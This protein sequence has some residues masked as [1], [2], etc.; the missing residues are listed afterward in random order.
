MRVD[1][2]S[3][4][5]K[6][7]KEQR[8]YRRR[9]AVFLCL[10]VLVAFG[11][12]AALKLYGQAMTHKME[13]LDCQYTVHEHT[14]ECY[15]RDAEGNLGTEAVCGYA[16]YVIHQHNDECYDKEGRLVCSLEE[17][18]PH[19]HTEECWLTEKVLVCGE[20]TGEARDGGEALSGEE[21]PEN[22]ADLPG[23]ETPENGEALPAAGA[24]ES[25]TASV[26]E[27][28]SDQEAAEEVSSDTADIAA[29]VQ[30][31]LICTA[32]VHKHE[33][34]C[35]EEVLSC[36]F[37]EEHTHGEECLNRTLECTV[38]EHTHGEGCYDAEGKLICTLEE[39]THKIGC[40]DSDGNLICTEELHTHGADCMDG[41]GNIVCG[42][43][44]HT[45]HFG[46]CYRQ[47]HI[48]G[49]ETHTH[50][51]SCYTQKLIC[52]MEEHEHTEECYAQPEPQSEEAGVGES[53][54]ASEVTGEVSVPEIPTESETQNPAEGSEEGA[55]EHVHTEDCY[56]EVRTLICGE[57][58]LH[59][60]DNSCY[61]SD[62]FDEE[63]NLIQ[64]SRPSCGLL[65]L[66]E[67]M[68]VHTD[69]E[70]SCFKTVEL[71]PEEVAALN[72][73]AKLHIHE[74]SCYDGEGNLICGHNATHIHIPECYDETGKL[75]CGYGEEEKKEYY[76]GKEEH[77]H[78]AECCDAEGNLTC[79]KGE[80]AHDESCQEE[81]A[82]LC[83]KE[84][85][86]HSAEC[87][88]TEGNLTCEK[89]EHAH[90]E[91]CLEKQ[92]EPENEK[93][94][95]GIGYLVKVTYPDS[96]KISEKAELI[97]RQITEESDPERFA[98]RQAEARE[99]LENENINVHAL[100]DI[101][102]YLDGEE[103]EPQDTVNVTI[104]LLDENGLPEGTPMQIV[105]FAESGNE[106]LESGDIDSEGNAN[107]ETD[108]FSEF[109]VVGGDG[110]IAIITGDG[111]ESDDAEE[112]VYICGKEEHTHGEGCYDGS[113]NLICS[114][115][116]HTHD[117]SCL[118][119]SL[120]ICGEREHVHSEECYDENQTLICEKKE[121]THEAACLE[122]KA[123][124][125]VEKV[126][127]LIAAL[128]DQ[129]E[130]AGK[131]AEY[132]EAE[133][134]DE[135]AYAA[136]TE[137]LTVQIQDAYNAYLGLN[138][139]LRKYVTGTDYLL[140]LAEIMG[141]SLLDEQSAN[142]EGVPSYAAFVPI[143]E[144]GEKPSGM[145][146]ELLYGD[147]NSTH[148]DKKD[149]GGETPNY[150]NDTMQGYF[151]LNTTGV[152]GTA[153]I[154]EVT[155]SLYIP[156]EY[157]DKDKIYIPEFND[158]IALHEISKVTEETRDGKGYYKISLKLKN[159]TPT[160]A[161]KFSFNMKFK[162]AEV[163]EDYELK[164]FATL[165]FGEGDG[166]KK[167]S[168][169]E[170]I[171]RPK[172]EDPII[173]KYVNTNK[174]D[175]MKDDDTRV[176][177]TVSEAGL[178]EDNKYVSF[179]Y[180]LG[181][182]SW[183]LR[184]YDKITLTDKLPLYKDVNGVDR[185]AVFDEAANPG[186]TYNEQEHTVS[187]VFEV[188]PEW[189][190]EG[191]AKYDEKLMKQIQEAELKL[192]FPGCKIDG[193]EEKEVEGDNGESVIKKFFTKRLT[194][195][196][197]A[198]CEP[199]KPSEEESPDTC[200]DSIDFILTS[201][202]GADG[203]FAKGNSA[204]T[205]M[206]TKIARSAA[207]KWSLGFKNKSSSNLVNLVIGDLE[208]D[209]RLKFHSIVFD[210]TTNKN[211]IQNLAYVE[212]FTYDNGG[213]TG[214]GTPANP[215]KQGDIYDL[216]DPAKY[217]E[218]FKDTGYSYDFGA[219]TWTLTLDPEKEYKGIK[220]YFKDGFTVPVNGE[221]PTIWP[222][223]TFRNPDEKRFIE[224]EENKAENSYWNKA[225]IAY[226]DEKYANPGDTY[227]FLF[228]ENHFDL[229]GN[230]ENLWI[231]KS[232]TQ[233]NWN[234]PDK[235]DNGNLVYDYYNKKS[236]GFFYL[237]VKG[238]LNEGKD[239]KNLR[240]IDLLPEALEPY[241][242]ME[243]GTGDW[244]VK[245]YQVIPNYHN[246][247][248]TAMI[249]YL[250][251]DEV[252][253]TLDVWDG[254]SDKYVKFTPKVRVKPDA[255]PGTFVNEVY[256]LG[257]D[258]EEPPTDHDSKADIYEMQG[259]DKTKL[260]RYG[261]A[262]GSISTAEALYAEKFIAKD[263][264]NDW[265][266]TTLRFKVGDSFQYKLSLNN[267]APD[268]SHTNLTVYDVLPRIDDRSINNQVSRGSE[269]TVNLKGALTP[270]EGYQVW[271]TTSDEVYKK[272]MASLV[273]EE[274]I[275]MQ[276]IT[277]WSKVT[278]FKFMANEDVVFSTGKIEF[279]VPVKI[280]ETLTGDS[281]KILDEKSAQDRETGTA[282]VLEATNSFGY[283]TGSFTTAQNVESNYVKAQIS[284]AGF[285][286]QKTDE[287]GRI[288]PGAE[289]K[290]EKQKESTSVPPTQ[291][292]D[293][294]GE[295]VQ[296]DG[297]G[298]T[299]QDSGDETQGNTNQT[300]DWEQIGTTV[301][302]DADGKISFKNLT[303]G[304]YR[305]TEVKAPDGYK[306]LE[307]PITVT[308][309]LNETT[310]EYTVTAAGLTGSGTGNDPFAIVNATLY[311]LP[312]TGGM[313]SKLYTMA[314]AAF[315]TFGAGFLYKKKFRERRA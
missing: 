5:G 254:K 247:G 299:A 297:E 47:E 260:I 119:E 107:F 291:Q 162:T 61:A 49:K 270:P 173:T 75:I 94:C 244:Y 85:H 163:P 294:P 241:E 208:I 259:S 191:A 66:E 118:E 301:I 146:L 308:I 149:A 154:N 216:T 296:S 268:T 309:T 239:Y 194:N 222:F 19:T 179:W 103:I 134:A 1:F 303:V 53:Q 120:Y 145:V 95:E 267:T 274:S 212:A 187:R 29:W 109:M 59:T 72:N 298:G 256:L 169:A 127:Q 135:E 92:A 271:Y 113:Q 287:K 62:C 219:W 189:E 252:R 6:L 126:N 240:V 25:E 197:S 69:N 253:K 302:S 26:E 264:S 110:N 278:A 314:G 116:E 205:I 21:T 89:E 235:D 153:T 313:G 55:K 39:H 46:G 132:E 98:Q 295:S 101:G 192:R 54:S 174:F 143:G 185:Y 44:E 159:Y 289:F 90:D 78:G 142:P 122:A 67:H 10:A 312:E 183:S 73:G 217:A 220:I 245:E 180:K 233:D 2:L 156:Q 104:Q 42:W 224:G 248:R 129:E 223:S 100:F 286:V 31:E 225:Y 193:F 310:M 130:I 292:P 43:E 138:K 275:W 273:N 141:V 83:G 213:E 269:F 282:V 263:N 272:D 65:Q 22:G 133:D 195:E 288:L 124:E 306:I 166:K 18:G 266:K 238:S 258:L 285:V 250:D 97:V 305:L 203:W 184:A 207:Y 14:E 311:E 144:Q 13:V 290:L 115:E 261:R 131:M 198:V 8:Q 3:R 190:K 229:I 176:T 276:S 161:V 117:E 64:G 28:V 231:E 155:M 232:A 170:N 87:C 128:P 96:A 211:F 210:N 81:K 112:K 230:S 307:E 7:L 280:T 199:A 23:E 48:C 249:F 71:T 12:V 136:Y 11:T 114:K 182:D 51:E 204:N 293:Q 243:Y 80:H 123:R 102:F 315:L 218:Y 93:T 70:D 171:Y 36:G 121:H 56:R 215:E 151:K 168:T 281:L 251:V 164:I 148:D 50:E 265:K 15:E 255:S 221:I 237:N 234:Y 262:S 181:K 105:H 91:T 9:L 242:P 140:A 68:H 41:D 139:V 157:I 200:E 246:S 206:D 196:V 300:S 160:G 177:G 186:W 178:V 137:A 24:P 76:C 58:E 172:Y 16:D 150:T 63:G 52:G 277:D 34:V 33:P 30:P 279:V 17:H 57:Q 4:A 35:Y 108:S 86:T 60:H 188:N 257:D 147:G 201:Q 227:Y 214:E 228:S 74:D 202:P 304:T 209:E 79:E 283:S 84:E 284:L 175:N 27:A 165:E 40:F 125:E 20:E 167:A 38:S 77:T 226:Q 32:A 88:D 99:A 152:L 111:L 37:E 158:S 236:C 106:V 45:E 82:Y